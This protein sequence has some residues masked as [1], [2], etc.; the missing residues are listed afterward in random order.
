MHED[1]R[2]KLEMNKKNSISSSSE[3]T[4]RLHR[5]TQMMILGKKVILINPWRQFSEFSCCFFQ[6]FWKI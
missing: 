2:I 3:L 5:I 6:A 1:E 4:S